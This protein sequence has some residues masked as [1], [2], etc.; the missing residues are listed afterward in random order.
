M[1]GPV[2][3]PGLVKCSEQ[4]VK[5]VALNTRGVMRARFAGEFA[6]FLGCLTWLR[7]RINYCAIYVRAI[8]DELLYERPFIGRLLGRGRMDDTSGEENQRHARNP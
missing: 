5:L 2:L 8:S 3:P 4:G 7:C 1:S 6:Q